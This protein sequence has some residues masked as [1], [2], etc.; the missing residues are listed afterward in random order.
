MK[1][2]SADRYNWARLTLPCVS[3]DLKIS[4]FT[5]FAVGMLAHG[6]CYLNM[7][8]G[9]DNNYIYYSASNIDLFGGAASG[10]WLA[11]SFLIFFNLVNTPLWYGFWMLLFIGI[12]AFLICRTYKIQSQVLI[13]IISALMVT[14][15]TVIS[16]NMYLPSGPTYCLA[17]MMACLAVYSIEL[18]PHGWIAAFL[19][20]LVTDACYT[21][22]LSFAACLMILAWIRRLLIKERP[23]KKLALEQIRDVLVLGTSLAATLLISKVIMHFFQISEQQRLSEALNFGLAETAAKASNIIL[24]AIRRLF[25]PHQIGYM[26]TFAIL[27]QVLIVIFVFLNLLY[28]LFGEKKRRSLSEILLFV[29]NI[30]V[31]PIAMDTLGI[32]QGYSHQLMM[33]AYITP[34]LAAIVFYSMTAETLNMKNA[35]HF[36]RYAGW[37]LIT[38]TSLFVLFCV[39]LANSAYTFKYQQYETAK[40]VANRIV[41]RVETQEDYESGTTPVLF[42]GYPNT[43]S[44][45]FIE[46]PNLVGLTGADNYSAFS[47]HEAFSNIIHQIIGSDMK[48]IDEHRIFYTTTEENAEILRKA[49][50]MTTTPELQK[51]LDEVKPFP[52][53]NCCIW[54]NNV[55]V[56][57]LSD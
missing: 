47:H 48:I 22:Y 34:W 51:V 45:Y 25:V 4:L 24:I 37:Y 41:D 36:L 3:S 6:F 56:V 39:K 50:Y 10:R 29:I 33:Y 9:H 38:C 12:S 35:R 17:L 19:C 53:E 42:V 49:G 8:L 11:N 16:T 15:P 52:N 23:L 27:L 46:Y 2:N 20:L 54:L 44:A 31:I 13:A 26:T 43:G 7:L 40:L 57:K 28:L 1:L 18:K 14:Y 30:L 55:L 21:A 5:S 32:I